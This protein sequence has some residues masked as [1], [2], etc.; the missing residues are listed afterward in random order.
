MDHQ[1]GLYHNST[2]DDVDQLYN[3]LRYHMIQGTD[4]DI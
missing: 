1:L 4:R 3:W 2:L